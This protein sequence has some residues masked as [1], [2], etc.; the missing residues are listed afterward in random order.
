MSDTTE[1]TFNE[2]ERGFKNSV[3]KTWKSWRVKE[4]MMKE[5]W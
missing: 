3:K 2:K 4:I 1:Q 5:M